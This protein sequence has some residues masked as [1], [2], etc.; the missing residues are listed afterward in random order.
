MDKITSLRGPVEF[1]NGE[2]VLNIPLAAGGDQLIE[3]S[4]GIGVAD[5]EVLRIVIR[6]WLAEKLGVE[7]GTVMHVDNANGKFNIRR[8]E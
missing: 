6:A 3:C 5:G 1:E 7:E 4:H 2:L 8:A